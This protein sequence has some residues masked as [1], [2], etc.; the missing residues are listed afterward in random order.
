[1]TTIMM[2]MLMY[3]YSFGNDP[4]SGRGRRMPL[5]RARVAECVWCS[6]VSCTTAAARRQLGRGGGQAA[7]VRS[8]ASQCRPRWRA[9]LPGPDQVL[10][11]EAA[12]RRM[13]C[14]AGSPAC[15]RGRPSTVK[16]VTGRPHRAQKKTKGTTTN[17]LRTMSGS[18]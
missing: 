5:W 3:A 1:M 4:A 15:R 7:C 8:S 2:M 14:P 18:L 9:S 11:P 13:H 10:L 6:W 17:P 12:S 16:L